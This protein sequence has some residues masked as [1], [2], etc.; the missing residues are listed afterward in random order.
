MRVAV[1]GA[2]GQLGSDIVFVL[3]DDAIPLTHQDV[4]V[5]DAS[6]L[7]VIRDLKPDVIV[8]TAAYHKVDECE[9]NPLKTF[10]VNSVGALNVA[11]IANEVDAINIYIST[12]FVFDGKK[13]RPY[14]EDDQPNPVNV[15]G[16]SK[17]IGEIVTRNYSRKY[18]IIRLASLFGVKGARG[19]GGNFIDKITE[20]ARRGEPIRVVD[21]MIMS[22]TYTKDVARMLKK[23]LEL[24]P[25]YG[26]YH[27]VNE[28]YCSWYELAKTVFEIIGWDA[29]IKPIKT[30]DLN[31]VARRPLFSALENRRLHK[32]GFRMRPW[33]EA[34]KEYLVERGLVK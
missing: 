7:D 8:N 1:I 2:S 6:S 18:Y 32:L 34:L 9:L 3:G 11:K 13:G 28:G 15:Y 29:D 24:R 19:K 33:R 20:K 16:L 25:E 31:L 4:D 23:L 17:Y 21:D 26:V 10:N 22:P 27:M 12:D 30:R 5:T 14:N